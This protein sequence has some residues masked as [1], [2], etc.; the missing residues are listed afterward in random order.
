MSEIEIGSRVLLTVPNGGY[1]SSKIVGEY[2]ILEF[3]PSGTWVKLMN[4]DGRRYWRQR[5]EVSVVEVLSAPIKA[6]A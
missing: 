2:K 1:G 4:A 6:P 3:S 5:V